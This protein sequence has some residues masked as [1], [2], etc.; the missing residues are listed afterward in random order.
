MKAVKVEDETQVF[1]KSSM[2]TFWLSADSRFALAMCR[3]GCA[4]L[5]KLSMNKGVVSKG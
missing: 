4:A 3:Y 1:D 2:E 5:T